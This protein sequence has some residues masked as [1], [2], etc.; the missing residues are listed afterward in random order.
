MK[1]D[2][3]ELLRTAID[4]STSAGN[5]FYKIES[6]PFPLPL[7]VQIGAA[8]ED[9]IAEKYN[10]T[11][12]GAYSTGSYSDNEITIGAEF[13]YD[14]L[15]FVRGGYVDVLSQN[16]SEQKVFGPSFGAGVKITTV[17]NLSVDYAYRTADKFKANQ[18]ITLKIFF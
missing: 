10:Y 4:T 12:S 14:D 16:S 9:K 17:F 7:Q 1:F 15:F 18:M 11:I 6:A 13:N 2:G 8:Y 5:Q 3:P